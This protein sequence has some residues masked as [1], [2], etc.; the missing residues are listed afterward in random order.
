MIGKHR[1]SVHTTLYLSRCPL[2]H[3]VSAVMIEYVGIDE[4]FNHVIAFAS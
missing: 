2:L 1:F 3:T 4:N